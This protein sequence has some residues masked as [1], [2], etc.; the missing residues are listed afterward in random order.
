M[1]CVACGFAGA[2]ERSE[3]TAQGYRRFR[4]RDCSKQYNER[5]HRLALEVE[6]LR[7]EGVVGQAAIARALTERSVPTPRGGAGWTHTTVA[8]VLL[9]AA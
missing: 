5:A 2:T 9:R 8:Q 7:A 4:C 3:R 1:D 6:R